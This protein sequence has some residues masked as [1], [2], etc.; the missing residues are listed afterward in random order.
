MK[1]TT[2]PS[3]TVD[4]R[5]DQ[6]LMLAG[7]KIGT[8]AQITLG[9]RIKTHVSIAIRFDV[10]ATDY[11]IVQ[12]IDDNLELATLKAITDGKEKHGELYR[13]I[14]DLEEDLLASGLTG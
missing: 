5:H 1:L 3:Q 6:D 7:R 2:Q 12:G 11:E 9:T 8:A 4:P 13:K 10:G 14:Q